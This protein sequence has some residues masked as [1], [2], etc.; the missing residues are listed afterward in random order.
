M[1]TRQVL[2]RAARL[3][4]SGD[5]QQQMPQAPVVS[6]GR[7]GALHCLVPLHNVSPGSRGIIRD[8]LVGAVS[9]AAFSIWLQCASVPPTP[10]P[11]R[12]TLPPRMWS[13]QLLLLSLL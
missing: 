9:L 11:S 5:L 3:V 10:T 13:K 12:S 8:S 6:G 2:G 7:W 4:G 1:L